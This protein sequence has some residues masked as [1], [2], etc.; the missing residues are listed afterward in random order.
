[1]A[2]ALEWLQLDDSDRRLNELAWHSC[3]GAST[4]EDAERAARWAREAGDR[5][6]AQLAFEAAADHYRRGLDV[7]QQRN[8]DLAVTIGLLLELGAVLNK[9]GRAAD[10]QPV[11]VAAADHIRAI[12]RPDLLAEAALGYGGVLPAFADHMDDTGR[13]LLEESLA[14][15]PTAGTEGLRACLL[16]RLAHWTYWQKPRPDRDHDCSQALELARASGDPATVA[17]VLNSCYWALDGPDDLDEQLWRG[18]EITRLGESL[19][20][21]E[22][23]LQGL[24]CRLHVLLTNGDFSDADQV[25][26]ASEQL[27][28]EVRQPEYLRLGTT[29]RAFMAGVNGEWDEAERLAE[30]NLAT[31]QAARHPHVVTVYVA[32]VLPWRWLQGRAG[33]LAALIE[34]SLRFDPRRV[35]SHCVLPWAY[36]DHDAG[37]ARSLLDTV[38]PRWFTEREHD[39]DWLAICAMTAMAVESLGDAA[40]A[41]RLY[42]ALLP[43]A[44][45][46]CTAGQ[47]SFLGTMQHHLG[48]LALVAGDYDAAVTHLD[49]AADRHEQMSA[50]P[51]LALTRQARARALLG[52]RSSG[53]ADEA[54]RMIDQAASAAK[55]LQLGAVTIRLDRLLETQD[56]P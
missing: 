19:A 12:G 5:A 3:E 4:R 45:R 33:E 36:C 13:A 56:R 41:E 7:I 55:E 20:D 54:G 23:L 32:Q 37:H 26:Q 28:K 30:A 27:A 35:I 6:A 49:R 21:R 18:E 14:Q 48:S 34:S 22:I 11:F 25:A 51:F 50:W 40:W 15:L 39:L 16:A 52:R 29:Y 43:Y 47:S 44:D 42:P 10:G 38:D 1:M 17:A 31:M 9:S 8:G 53:D 46:N 24:K 2:L